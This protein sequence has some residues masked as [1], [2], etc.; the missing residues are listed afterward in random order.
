L[1]SVEHALI[2]PD[3]LPM[4]SFVERVGQLQDEFSA[5]CAAATDPQTTTALFEQTARHLH[6]LSAALTGPTTAARHAWIALVYDYEALRALIKRHRMPIPRELRLGSIKPTN[7]GRNIFHAAMALG[8]VLLYELV[9]DRTGML[10]LCAAVLAGYA[11]LEVVRRRSETF[12]TKL[13]ATSFGTLSR[14]QET[15][16][17]P[18][19]AWFIL[20]VLVGAALFEQHAIEVGVLVLGFGD[21][22]AALAGKRWGRTTIIGDK[23][24]VGAVAFFVVS[25]VVVAAFVALVLP[26]ASWLSLS[27]LVTAPALAGVG[28]ELFSGPLD[29]NLT[30]SLVAGAV[31]AAILAI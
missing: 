18:G 28:T 2:R 23:T 21:P 15:H 25:A 7:V 9:F 14:P 11:G 5:A 16:A 19:G 20:G 22:A 31:A 17:L 24:V 13:F 27:L 30:I 6:E 26:H 4:P 1:I 8:G 10:I 12:N 29:D 3:A